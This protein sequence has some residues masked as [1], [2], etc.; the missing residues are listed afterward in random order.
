MDKLGVGRA[1][2]EPKAT[3]Y[4]TEM[5]DMVKRLIE[6]NFAYESDRKCLFFSQ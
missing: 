3:E 4:I 1:D 6:K 2:I 5:I